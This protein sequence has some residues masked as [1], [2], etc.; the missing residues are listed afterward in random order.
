MAKHSSKRSA[1]KPR[2]APTLKRQPNHEQIAQPD[3]ERDLAL[4]MSGLPRSSNP[5]LA[6]HS[7]D[8]LQKTIGNQAVQRLLADQTRQADSQI[9]RKDAPD[10]KIQRGIMDY[11]NPLGGILNAS[12]RQSAVEAC[13]IGSGTGA[14]P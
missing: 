7:I 3:L 4:M 8:R 10:S 12:S 2:P 6:Q 9:S 5:A 13:W 14:P 11:L 1:Y